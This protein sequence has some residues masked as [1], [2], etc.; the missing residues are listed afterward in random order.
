MPRT[1]TIRSFQGATPKLGARVYVDPTATLIGTLSI[2]DDSSF[3]PMVVVRGDV[4]L[5]Q[6]GQRTNVQDGS[7]LHVSHA[8]EH[9]APDGYPLV[10]GD[11]VTIGHK[12][13][14]HGCTIGHRCL[15]GMG[16]LIMDG[17]VVE[18]EVM[19]GANTLVTPGKRLLSGYLYM[20][21]PVKQVRPLTEA[22]IQFLTYSARHYL[23]LKDKYLAQSL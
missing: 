16:S 22:E 19:I 17:V 7:V 3:W 9:T 21:T 11:D 4:N 18:N 2:G 6:I 8:G 20:G 13:L 15:I 1:H 5:I 14:L 12:V 10:I 23:S